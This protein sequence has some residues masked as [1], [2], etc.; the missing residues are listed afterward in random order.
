MFILRLEHEVLLLA[1]D[2][3]E[4]VGPCTMTGKRGLN[5]TLIRSSISKSQKARVRDQGERGERS[6]RIDNY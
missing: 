6:E 1:V 4:A 2:E 3:Y 5:A